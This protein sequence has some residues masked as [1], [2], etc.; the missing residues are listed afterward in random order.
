MSQDRI[1]ILFL[2]RDLSG[3]GAEKVLVSWLHGLSLE[4]FEPIV[5]LAHASGERLADVPAH[6]PVHCLSGDYAPH[7]HFIARTYRF[8]KLLGM[9]KPDLVVSNMPYS[10][11]IHLSAI[12]GLPRTGRHVCWLHTPAGCSERFWE[13]ALLRLLYPS[14]DQHVAVSKAVASSFTRLYRRVRPQRVSVAYNRHPAELLR[15]QALGPAPEWPGTGVRLLVVG[16]LSKEKRYAYLLRAL[17]GLCHLD[18][19]LCI[20]GNGPEHASLL[21]IIQK[22]HLTGR[23]SMSGYVANPYPFFR[24]ADLCISTS[25]HEGCPGVVI[26]AMALGKPM[27]ATEGIGGTNEILGG[28]AHGQLVPTNDIGALREALSQLI[29]SP[30]LRA[31][32]SRKALKGAACLE[33]QT[34]E[35]SELFASLWTGTSPEIGVPAGRA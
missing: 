13:R 3:G 35:P 15:A 7:P 20:L 8:R 19:S 30:Q 27:V 31:E 26:E 2:I 9:L 28:G 17:S 4:R 29:Q 33:R 10:H 22:H 21:S 34:A 5:V 16:R 11:A 12:L 6:V 1:R 14:A 25:S 24:A 18:W 23:V 32:L